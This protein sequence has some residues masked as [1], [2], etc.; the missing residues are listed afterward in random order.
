VAHTEKPIMTSRA[1]AVEILKKVKRMEL[2][3]EVLKKVN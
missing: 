1:N 3:E 2:M